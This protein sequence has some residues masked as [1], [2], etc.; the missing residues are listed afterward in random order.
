MGIEP[1]TPSPAWFLLNH[2]A[3]EVL[4][5]RYYWEGMKVDVGRH[6]SRCTCHLNKANNT[7]RHAPLQPL[8]A[9]APFK[10]IHVDHVGPFEKTDKGH[11][12]DLMMVDRFTKWV[13]IAVVKGKDMSKAADKFEKR[14][15]ARW[16]AKATVIA[17]NASKRWSRIST[18][19][20]DWPNGTTKRCAN[21]FGVT[22]TMNRMIGI[23]SCQESNLLW[24]L[25]KKKIL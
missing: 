3:K 5:Q 12:Y 7:K 4:F 24:T 19:P 18:T 10:H 1:M 17:D 14:I 23:N 15:V 11:L 21:L 20:T 8:R 25:Q 22:S 13:E 9:N 2:W 16:R 6:V